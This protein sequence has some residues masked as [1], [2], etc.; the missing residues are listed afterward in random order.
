MALPVAASVVSSG[1]SGY[2]TVF[3]DRVA[4]DTLQSNLFMYPACELKTMPRL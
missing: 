3:Y 2:P 1:L 4:L